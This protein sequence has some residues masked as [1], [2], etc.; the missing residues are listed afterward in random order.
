METALT[1]KNLFGK[2]EVRWLPIPGYEGFYEA[3]NTGEIRRIGGEILKKYK[4]KYYTVAL[5]VDG[6]PKTKSVHRLVAYA[7]KG[8]SR[9]VVDHDDNDRYNNHE[10]N[11]VYRTQR[12]NTSKGAL[13]YTTNPPQYKSTPYRVRIRIKGKLVDLGS[14]H[15]PEEAINV[16]NN[17]KQ[18]LC[19]L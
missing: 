15:T 10:T 2:D 18:E 9:L 6:L 12:E 1:V 17:K 16:Y 5:S 4:G 8:I 7:F 19:N 14:Y 13:G 3:S 11:L